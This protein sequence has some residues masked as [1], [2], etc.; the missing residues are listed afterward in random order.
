[1]KRRLA[2]LLALSLALTSFPVA[3]AAAAEATDPTAIEQ[4]AVTEEKEI[5]E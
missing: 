5:A 2:L 4:V 3:G 1:M